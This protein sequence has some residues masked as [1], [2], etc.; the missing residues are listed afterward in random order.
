MNDVKIH[1]NKE[2]SNILKDQLGNA[3]KE[4]MSAINAECGSIFLF[5]SERKDLVLKEFHNT[6]NL[7][8]QGLRQKVWEGVAGRVAGM[9][10]PVLVKNLDVDAR[11]Q[12]NGFKHYRTNSFIS[13]PLFGSR[14]LI[15]LINLADKANGKPF[16]EE[17]LKI[18]SAIANYASSVADSLN[19][20]LE[21]K[22]KYASVGKLAAGVVHEINNPLDGIIR[23]TN[24]LLEKMEHNSSV[25][26]YLMEVK[27]G[28]NRIANITKS[29]LQFSH[30]VNSPSS[31]RYADMHQLIDESLNM[32]NGKLNGT[33][34][35]EKEYKEKLSRILDLG[36]EHVFVNI[37]KNALDAMPSGGQL[38]ISTDLNDSW[39][40][41]S[42]KDT[43]SGIPSEYKE[44]IFE[45]FFTTKTMD[46]GTGLGLAICREIVGKYGGKIQVQSS[47]GEGTT[48]TVIIP[49]TY[50]E[51]A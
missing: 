17:D 31:R 10:K 16:S 24:I 37:I 19:D 18:A 49:K 47:S 36:L 40:G 22:E 51:N 34:K 30:Q 42:F 21:L 11:F 45:P 39:V 7:Y 38:K 43:G 1:E 3:L 32:F 5:D 35:I 44:R 29:L 33:I 25:R 20:Y 2:I 48:F 13:V 8:L 46:K 27:N 6:K 12:R 28:L 4:I 50:L 23:Y 41:V 9:K 26:E 14:G 15:G